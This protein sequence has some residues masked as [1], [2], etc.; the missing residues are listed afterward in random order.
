MGMAKRRLLNTYQ[1]TTLPE[2][3]YLSWKTGALRERQNDIEKRINEDT[4]S[5]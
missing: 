1:Y 3:K 5:K 4:L 2:E